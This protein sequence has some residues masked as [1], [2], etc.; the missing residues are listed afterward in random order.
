MGHSGRSAQWP[1][2]MVS[3]TTVSDSNLG[4]RVWE[5]EKSTSI[6]LSWWVRSN[7]ATG[8]GKWFWREREIQETLEKEVLAV[9]ADLRGIRHTGCGYIP[10][11]NSSFCREWHNSL[12]I[13]TVVTLF[14]FCSRKLSPTNV[15]P[16]GGLTLTLLPL[17]VKSQSEDL[18]W[19]ILPFARW[20]N[21]FLESFFN[22]L[23][24][25]CH[26]GQ[27]RRLSALFIEIIFLYFLKYLLHIFLVATNVTSWWLI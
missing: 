6:W 14:F 2:L 3:Q 24:Q 20:N 5:K 11:N 17:H 9:P 22:L 23:K 8:S 25:C 21:S 26:Q 15:L 13:H 19:S 7:Y 10:V 16:K 1:S 12:P 4:H 18:K 27:A